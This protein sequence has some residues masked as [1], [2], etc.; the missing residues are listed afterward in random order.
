MLEKYRTLHFIGIGGVAMY[1]LAR[2]SL[3][4]GC[5]VSGSDTH[6]NSFTKDL[7]CRGAVIYKSHSENNISACDMTVYSLSIAEDNPELK[8]AKAL[9]IPTLTRAEFM[10]RLMMSYKKRLAVSGSH[11]KSTVTAMLAHIFINQGKNP[12]VMVGAE[13][14]DGLPLIIGSN[15]YLIYEACEYRDSFLKFSPTSVT[16]TNLELD[17]TDYFKSLED[18]KRSFMFSINGAENFAVLNG[19][20]KNLASLI[21]TLDTDIYTVG[22]L[23]TADFNYTLRSFGN[24]IGYSIKHGGEH[25]G[26]FILKTSAVFNISNAMCAIATAYGEGIPIEASARALESFKGIARRMEHIGYHR[27]RRVIY[28]YAHHP[29]EI[30]A[31]INALHETEGRL[32]VIFRPHTYTRTRDFWDGFV[33]ALS[34]ADDL[35]IT[36]IFPAR[37]P[38]IEGITAE[39][40]AEASGGIYLPEKKIIQAVD[41]FTSGTV[42]LMGAGDLEGIKNILVRKNI[43]SP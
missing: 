17:H 27:G 43:K 32:T 19:D 21:S 31:V 13:V 7:E 3:E 37:E 30:A 9:G 39:R 36:D 23:G 12:T 24:G 38:P 2:L 5:L 8:R 29:T 6:P 41:S 16:V 4:A 10:G 33:R 34:M 18:I 14:K 20:D 15:E 28:D 40:L 35:I 22:A 42:V 26:D 11:G 25:I 1:S